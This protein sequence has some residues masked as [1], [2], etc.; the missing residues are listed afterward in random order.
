MYTGKESVAYDLSRFDNRK[1]VKEADK[2]RE[3]EQPKV[4]PK[5]NIITVP[6]VLA[7]LA[8]AALCF[9]MIHN[10]MVMTQM[11]AENQKL[12]NQLAEYRDEEVLLRAKQ[13]GIYDLSEIEDYA[14]NNLGMVKFE[15]TQIEYIEM[16]K[17]DKSEGT[18]ITKGASG[19]SESLLD[20]IKSGILSIVEYFR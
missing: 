18:Y 6:A 1:R 10:Y 19:D 7:V 8:A 3:V 14:Q 2:L 13:E 11:T 15:K 9:V 17:P 4:L 16:E 5:K 20:T 12:S